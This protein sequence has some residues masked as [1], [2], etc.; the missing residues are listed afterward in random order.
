MFVEKSLRNVMGYTITM[1][2]IRVKHYSFDSEF[3]YLG[4]DLGVSPESCVPPESQ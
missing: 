1:I 4:D 3:L 2:T